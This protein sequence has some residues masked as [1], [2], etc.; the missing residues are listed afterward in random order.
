M[1]R[2]LTRFGL[3]ALA[4]VLLAGCASDG[5]I[6]PRGHRGP[7]GP[8]GPAGQAGPPGLEG[9]RGPAGA[10][11]PQGIRGERGAQG[12]QGV[13]GA[14][15]A[16]GLQGAQ[17][18]PGDTGQPGPQGIQGEK[19][20]T[21]PQ[22][23]PGEAGSAGSEAELRDLQEQ[24][25]ALTERLALLEGNPALPPSFG[26]EALTPGSTLSRNP[27]VYDRG[28]LDVTVETPSSAEIGIYTGKAGNRFG[29]LDVLDTGTSGADI[30]GGWMRNSHFGVVLTLRDG[31]SVFSVG[32]PTNA[33]PAFHGTWQGA[34]VGARSVIEN[35]EPVRQL[36][37]GTVRLNVRLTP[38]AF[39]HDAV[40]DFA[41]TRVSTEGLIRRNLGAFI[42]R[43][44]RET[45]GIFQAG[46]QA[47]WSGMEILDGDFGRRDIRVG[48]V[49]D[50]V[51]DPVTP[52]NY[53]AGRFYGPG[54]R[55][56]G[57]VFQEDGVLDMGTPGG[58]AAADDV[59]TT[60][61][62]AFGALR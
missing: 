18:I 29:G 49:S 19:G 21:G 42:P 50:L 61:I 11:G 32:A 12:P 2:C 51:P 25:D 27:A 56:V 13:R 58:A 6:G 24:I 33:N 52:T 22:G 34:M 43:T 45:D 62:G 44:R 9:E 48:N 38:T 1:R 40:V 54:A 55:E 35:G 31:W 39:G 7:A 17:G 41:I 23:V 57:G 53:L 8:P 4:A 47:V 14:Q 26:G 10:Q 15:G 60:I 37:S 46:Q 59:N 30:L 5:N 3:A 16:R 28:L 20:D 36:L